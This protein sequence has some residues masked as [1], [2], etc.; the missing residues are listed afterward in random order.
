MGNTYIIKDIPEELKR[1]FRLLC[2]KKQVTMK[3]EFI[4]F[5]NEEVEKAK[6]DPKQK[7]LFM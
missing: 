6:R 4:R 2:L 5:M 1:N 7:N 3:E